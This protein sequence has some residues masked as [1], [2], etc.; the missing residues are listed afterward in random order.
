MMRKIALGLLFFLLFIGLT[1]PAAEHFGVS[2]TNAIGIL[3]QNTTWTKAESPYTLTGP[4]AVNIGVTLTVQP[5]TI[6]NLNGFYIQ[7]NGTLIAIGTS[8]EKIQFSNGEIIFKPVSNGWNQQS[9]AGSQFQYVKF[10]SGK[11]SSSVSLKL[12]HCQ[13]NSDI[14]IGGASLITDNSLSSV[15]IA[16]ACTVQRNT[17]T[18]GLEITS[19][20]QS[21]ITGNTIN[22]GS[23]LTAV[24]VTG[25]SSVISNNK[26][27]GGGVVSF[28]PFRGENIY[29]AVEVRQGTSQIS[30]NHIDGGVLV[31]GSSI[32]TNNV[33]QNNSIQI[34]DGSPTI[35]G[36][37]FVDYGRI[38]V[39]RSSDSG[40]GSPVIF[41]NTV[42]CISVY[43]G[44][45][46]IQ[47]NTLRGNGFN[48]GIGF[49]QEYNRG[50]SVVENNYVYHCCYGL[51]CWS[52]GGNPSVIFRNNFVVDSEYGVTVSGG[53][54][55][56]QNNTLKNN[57]FGI[58][59]SE[60]VAV[61][62]I[63]Y[64]NIE[65]NKQGNLLVQNLTEHINA[66]N[67]WWGT[68]DEQAIGQ[69]IHDSK[70]DFNLA[71]V[72]STPF[73]TS[74][75]PQAMPEQP[76]SV[77]SIPET[78]FTILPTQQPIESTINP[79]NSPP[80]STA[81]LPVEIWSGVWFGLSWEQLMIAVLTV[82]VVVLLILL[83]FQRR[84]K[85]SLSASG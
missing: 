68:T 19:N 45:V 43:D 22:G 7:V 57:V 1:F 13:S 41:N 71:T 12:V 28:L 39:G 60:T 38:A 58:Y 9:D 74:S 50:N 35:S 69:T 42:S 40:V 75:N 70:Y 44:S 83:I 52:E 25:G 4:V 5:G 24:K 32:V 30:T 17:F 66:I 34:S 55:T 37:G 63:S 8:S 18:G 59:L 76:A 26:L 82:A 6:I 23:R 29:Y 36:N 48:L 77:L 54:V 81:V 72:T 80:T 46:Q 84:R 78:S 51:A 10:D 11:V 62:S 65:G 14:S 15:S 67:N 2:A 49:N 31:G 56:I 61:S 16:G 73:L 33:L 20:T 3:N 27:T 53:T 85:P 79:D 21:T 47:A 64:N